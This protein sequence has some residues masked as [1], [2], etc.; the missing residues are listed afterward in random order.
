MYA[1]LLHLLS[2]QISLGTNRLIRC[3][4]AVLVHKLSWKHG[5]PKFPAEMR[6]SLCSVLHWELSP[7]ACLQVSHSY[8]CSY[9]RQWRDFRGWQEIVIRE[10]KTSG[11]MNV[12]L[13]LYWIWDY[14]SAANLTGLSF[15]VLITGDSP[16]QT[17]QGLIKLWQPKA[18]AL[19]SWKY[20]GSCKGQT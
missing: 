10:L 8:L 17:N 2:G 9:S 5:N 11:L 12:Q 15:N 7:G 13:N 3:L 1:D 19:L 4:L 16:F 18:T 6:W 14:F 20:G